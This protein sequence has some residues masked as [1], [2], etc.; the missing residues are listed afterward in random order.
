MRQERYLREKRMRWLCMS[1]LATVIGGHACA[2]QAAVIPDAVAAT[3]PEAA[4]PTT[5]PAFSQPLDLPALW[6]IALV[7]N[8]E[9]REAAADVDAARGRC[10]QAGKYPN[11]HFQYEEEDLG[12][13][14]A[15]AGTIRF[16]LN[17]EI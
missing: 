4:D 6:G 2:A 14:Q 11:P 15:A 8:P 1:L 17:Q 3:Y 16:Q 10:L 5:L 13:S 9:L 12:T 7:Y